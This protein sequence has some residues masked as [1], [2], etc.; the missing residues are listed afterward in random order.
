[1]MQKKSS[2]LAATSQ[3]SGKVLDRLKKN[4]ITN[5]REVN[6]SDIEVEPLNG[7]LIDEGT[8]EVRYLYHETKVIFNTAKVFVNFEIVEPGPYFGKKLFRAFRVSELIGRP[9][10]NGRF[11]LKKRSELLME[12][13]RLFEL[14]GLRPD[15]ISL[16]PL[17][18]V[19]I[20]VKVRTVNKDY[21]QREL[22]GP[23]KY[24]VVGDFI[25]IEAGLLST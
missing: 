5:I 20:K 22:P 13:L 10:K 2:G 11:K 3:P 19:T 8:Y 6:L 7:L 9:G 16:K 25:K 1:M 4:N 14:Q 24:S 12:I 15:R 18:N 23:L 17:K 21:K